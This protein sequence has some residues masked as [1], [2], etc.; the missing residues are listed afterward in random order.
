MAQ[1]AQ[2]PRRAQAHLPVAVGQRR[3]QG[4]ARFSLADLA[5]GGRRLF[6][7]L[8]GLIGQGADQRRQHTGIPGQA[9]RANGGAAHVGIRLVGCQLRQ[10][11]QGRRMLEPAQDTHRFA[12]HAGIHIRQRLQ[13][14]HRGILQAQLAQGAQGAGPHERIGMAGPGQDQLP[15]LLGL[16]LAQA[17]GGRQAHRLGGVGQCGAQALHHFRSSQAS[18]SARLR[19]APQR[20]RRPTAHR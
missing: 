13:R 1:P 9:Q 4:L 16:E 5:Q 18:S 12:A 10:R 20:W 15:G 17:L 8:P 14:R 6:T 7:H 11:G 19:R 2:G 3:D